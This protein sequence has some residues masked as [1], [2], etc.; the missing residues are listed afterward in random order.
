MVAQEDPAPAS[1]GAGR[2]SRPG[3]VFVAVAAGVVMSNLD[4][5]VVNVALPQIGL[6]FRQESLGPVS[7]VLNAYAVIFAALLVPAGNVADRYGARRSYLAGIATFSASSLACSLAPGVWWLVGFRVLQ[8]AGAAMLIPASLGLLLT[9]APPGKRMRYVRG[10]TALS[11]L[12]AALGPAL[13]GLLTD[14]SWRWVFLINVPVGAAVLAVGPALLPRPSAHNRPAGID[15]AGVTLL[16]AGIGSVA[17]G[18]VE[19][20]AWGWASARVLGSLAAGVILLAAFV[21]HTARSPA[22][23]LPLEL[24]RV[25]GFARASAANLLFAVPFAAMLLSIVLWAQQVWHWSPLATGIAVAPGPLMVPPF[26]LF[27]GPALVKHAGPSLVTAG[28]SLIFA[29]GVI[30]WIAAMHASPAYPRMLPGMLITGVGVGLT[31]PTLI[32]TAVSALPPLAFSTGSAAVTM[33][34]QVGSVLGVAVLVAILDTSAHAART[35][36]AFDRGWWYT[37][38]AAGATAAACLAFGLAR[39]PQQN[40]AA[41]Q[42][43]SSST[44][45]TA[46]ADSSSADP[47]Q[48]VAMRVEGAA[49]LP[50]DA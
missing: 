1:A 34:R 46:Q 7:W 44:H 17:L 13:G 38:A 19:S 12:G 23:V 11:A 42:Q 29:V 3:W 49:G 9:A 21:A 39:K 33:A 18:L 30:S 10:W 15:A 43:T 47:P 20:P 32:A 48:A 41:R 14:A 31:L 4:T 24:L 16:S 27:I 25:P 36:V 40:I 22:P 26:A 6:H 45:S 37:A 50:T 5:F 28:G 8:A 2:R 35:V